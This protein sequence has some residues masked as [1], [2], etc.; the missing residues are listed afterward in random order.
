MPYKHVSCQ[1]MV[2]RICVC[3][4]TFAVISAEALNSGSWIT[5]GSMTTR[6]KTG[7]E[8]VME[9]SS[10][11]SKQVPETIGTHRAAKRRT[12]S[13]HGVG[14]RARRM[15]WSGAAS[16]AV[17][18]TVAAAYVVTYGGSV[19]DAYGAS[20]GRDSFAATKFSEQ[21]DRS[22]EDA[23]T[24]AGNGYDEQADSESDYGAATGSD[25]YGA[26]RTGG[27]SSAPGEAAA[28]S[29][30]S[31]KTFEVS[32]RG[33]NEVDTVGADGGRA[34]V[35]LTVDP[36]LGSVSFADLTTQNIFV[37]G[38]NAPEKFH[39]HQG[40]ANQNGDVV[41]DLTESA[42]AG[43]TSGSVEVD[44]EI[45]W[46][47]VKNPG[48]YYLNLH[49]A[50]FPD[51]A[52]RGQLT[53]AV[54]P[55]PPAPQPPAQNPTRA[56]FTVALSGAAEVPSGVGAPNGSGIVKLGLNARNG[57]IE[58]RIVKVDGVYGKGEQQIPTAF[59]IHRGTA[60]QNGDVVVDLTEKVSNGQKT[61]CGWAPK[62]LVK[63]IIASPENYY[64]NY[65]TASYPDGAIRGQ[66]V[67]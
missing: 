62:G 60:G 59:H 34:I 22:S 29:S 23:G 24:G 43:Q 35:K 33:E 18:S 5:S 12:G 25:G 56:K 20:S 36:E 4:A 11:S 45:A 50:S 9:S 30:A 6:D 49:T 47:I 39:L 27:G 42:L 55:A 8:I 32:L 14:S 1:L 54:T 65:H 15:L 66:L 17:L 57:A 3:L 37:D 51:G 38:E 67:N 2:H 40:G 19:N 52:A 63:R 31:A 64:L 58:F 61:G 41:V 16:V 44:S 53:S 21:D 10:N 7:S 48:N 46:R 13:Q 28:P 26:G